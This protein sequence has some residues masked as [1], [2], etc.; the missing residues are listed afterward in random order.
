[1]HRVILFAALMWPFAVLG[2]DETWAPMSGAEIRAALSDRSL[3][4]KSAH[5]EFNASG[6]TRYVAGRESWG[7][8]RVEGDT[9]CS[10]WPPSTLWAC[11]TMTQRGN[12]V[13]FIGKE[14]DV[15]EGVYLD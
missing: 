4:Y 2:G 6:Q 13:R 14:G 1:M 12:A 8:W 7:S 3:Q 15:T 10:Q 5:Q 9:Y 11:Y